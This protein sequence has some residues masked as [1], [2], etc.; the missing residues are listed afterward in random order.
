MDP[1]ADKLL[2]SSALFSFAWMNYVM[3]WMVW[4]IILRDIFVTG[5]RV[6]ALIKGRPIVTSAIAKW[7]TFSQMAVIALILS[8]INWLNFRGSGSQFYQATYYDAIG[9]AMLVVTIMTLISAIFYLVENS[10][11]IWRMIKSVFTLFTR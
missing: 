4:I 1:F 2:V 10:K 6:Y 5:V 11:L 3:W 9:I 7:K 8:Y